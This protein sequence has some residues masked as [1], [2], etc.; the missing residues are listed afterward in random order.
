MGIKDWLTQKAIDHQ[1]KQATSLTDAIDQVL[2]KKVER[3]RKEGK[4]V[5]KEN[6]LA[7]YRAL[8]ILGANKELVENRIEELKLVE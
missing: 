8:A 1:I 3:L 2:V 7:G 5:N 6:L 4:E